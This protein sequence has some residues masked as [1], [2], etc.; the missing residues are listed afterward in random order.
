V[1][2]DSSW[3]AEQVWE[4][5]ADTSGS[6]GGVSTYFSRP[7]WQ[8]ARGVG[9]TVYDRKGM[10]EVPDV[11]AVADASTSGAYIIDG[12]VTNQG[13]T[14]QAAPIW[15]GIMA[16][17]DQYLQKHGGHTLGFANPALYA[18]AQSPKP[19]PPFHDV[20]LGSNLAYSATPGYDMATGLGS[21]DAWNLAR[22]LLAYEKG[23]KR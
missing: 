9:N 23:G 18:L 14:S 10:R 5:P 6:G 20:T 13:G 16:L 8:K 21:P 19:Y 2:K 3:Y 15:A 11:S 12:K 1:R 7:S 22:D 4:G 17:I